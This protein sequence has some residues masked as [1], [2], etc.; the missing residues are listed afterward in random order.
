MTQLATTLKPR[1]FEH[2]FSTSNF[3]INLLSFALGHSFNK[4]KQWRSVLVNLLV[5][6]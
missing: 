2:L 4:T 6:N 3:T 5:L 1:L